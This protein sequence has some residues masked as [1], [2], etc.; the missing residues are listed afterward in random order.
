MAV[1]GILDWLAERNNAEEQVSRKFVL[2]TYI[3]IVQLLHVLCLFCVYVCIAY[4]CCLRAYF[5][6]LLSSDVFTNR[7]SSAVLTN[8]VSS[9]VNR[10]LNAVL[11][12][13]SAVVANRSSSAVVANCSSRYFITTH[14]LG[15][16]IHGHMHIR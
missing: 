4:C 15:G 2:S 14:V 6:F 5:L 12:S 8:C 3:S 7:L 16:I 11:A 10:A 13:L 1:Q 9:V